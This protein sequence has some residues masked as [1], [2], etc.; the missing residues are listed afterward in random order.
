MKKIREN[1][2]KLWAVES[3]VDDVRA[4]SA[5]FSCGKA[6]H[7]IENNNS[8]VCKPLMMKWNFKESL[9]VSCF[10]KEIS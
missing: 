6:F 2:K 5:V 1:F 4:G 9:S 10:N 8:N 7:A 3:Q